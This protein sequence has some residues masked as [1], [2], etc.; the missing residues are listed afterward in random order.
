[1]LG[2]SAMFDASAQIVMNQVAFNNIILNRNAADIYGIRLDLGQT[3]VNDLNSLNRL[4]QGMNLPAIRVYDQGYLADDGSRKGSFTRFVP[5][6]RYVLFGRRTSGVKI[7]NFALTWN[8]QAG[9]KPSAYTRVIDKSIA[10]GPPGGIE[11]HRGFNGGPT[12][13]YPGAI[14]VGTGI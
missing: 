13:E 12:L 4:L 14:V 2:T 1:M 3:P 6:N 8:L 11:V 9:G 7:G 5:S 10:Q